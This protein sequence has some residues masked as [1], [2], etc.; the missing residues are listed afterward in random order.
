MNK[1]LLEFF[2]E[3]LV[4]LKLNYYCVTGKLDVSVIPN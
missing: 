4:F 3:Q 2:S 1:H